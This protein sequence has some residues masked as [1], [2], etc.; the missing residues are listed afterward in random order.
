MPN[1]PIAFGFSSVW[2]G[3]GV[4]YVR[5]KSK[6]KNRKEEFFFRQTEMTKSVQK[7][8]RK[9]TNT[10]CFQHKIQSNTGKKKKKKH[11]TKTKI[12]QTSHRVFLE[13]KQI[14]EKKKLFPF[15]FPH[16]LSTQTPSKHKKYIQN[17]VYI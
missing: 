7:L 6:K 3:F 9:A 8:T 1:Q 2:L 14:K 10:D 12:E 17:H 11:K 15:A 5:N 16:F 4:W 13:T